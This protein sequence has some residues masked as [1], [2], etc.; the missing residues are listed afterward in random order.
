MCKVAPALPNGD[1]NGTKAVF[2]HRT[3]GDVKR[4]ARRTEESRMQRRRHV[5]DKE[6][7]LRPGEIL[8]VLSATKEEALVRKLA[9]RQDEKLF[10]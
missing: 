2:G 4:G 6:N 7:V 3:A 5:T 9:R 1:D 10:Q 8:R